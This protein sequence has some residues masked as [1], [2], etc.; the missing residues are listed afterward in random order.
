MAQVFF[1]SLSTLARTLTR[2]HNPPSPSAASAEKDK[3]VELFYDS[4]ITQVRAAATA[5][6]PLQTRCQSAC[7]ASTLAPGRQGFGVFACPGGRQ[8]SAPR[9]PG[10]LLQLLGALVLASEAGPGAEHT[11]SAN[12]GGCSL[13]A[14]SPSIAPCL[15]LPSQRLAK[16]SIPHC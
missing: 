8:L 2:T 16:P 11:P 5:A 1:S 10:C 13:K 9:G 7:A 3:F 15:A 14:R 6:S 4:H 12:T